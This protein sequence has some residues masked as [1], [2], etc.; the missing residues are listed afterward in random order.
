MRP[1]G[2]K[3]GEEDD[4]DDKVERLELV[5]RGA[6]A[7][8]WTASRA[9]QKIAIAMRK[10]LTRKPPKNQS[11]IAI[12]EAKSY[13]DGSMSEMTPQNTKN[14]VA[15]STI[16]WYCRLAPSEVGA[17]EEGAACECAAW[18]A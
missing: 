12:S 16:C 6:S 9:S 5:E 3:D 7:M 1:L 11:G 4:R 18:A 14:D 13:G 17:T 2:E 8:K 15:Q 10:R